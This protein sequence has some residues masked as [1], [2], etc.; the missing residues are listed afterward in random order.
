MSTVTQFGGNRATKS[1]VNYWADG[2]VSAQFGG[3]TGLVAGH[4]SITSGSLTANTLATQ[5]T[6]SGAGEVSSLICCTADATART[7]RM[8]VV[9]DGTTVFDAT[10]NSV[11]NAG[12]GICAAGTGA[13]NGSNNGTPIRFNSSLV[14]KVCSSLTETGKLVTSYLAQTF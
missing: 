5:L 2:G 6:I 13:A 8:Q 7:V 1:V 14:V 3:G 12:Y 4:K 9:A 10:S 11:S